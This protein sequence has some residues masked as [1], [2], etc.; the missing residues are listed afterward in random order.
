[1]IVRILLMA[2]LSAGFGVIWYTTQFY[3]L[4]FLT[5]TLKIDGVTATWLVMVALLLATP[6]FVTPIFC[7]TILCFPSWYPHWT[8]NK[9]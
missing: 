8:K 4:L 9:H 6:F 7:S 2:G 1:M 3:A 5:Q